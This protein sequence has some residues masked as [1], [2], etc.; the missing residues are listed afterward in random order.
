MIRLVVPGPPTGKGRPRFN[1]TTG[2]AYTPAGTERAENRVQLA[3]MD[4]GRPTL[5]DAEALVLRVEAVLGRPKSHYRTN[6]ALTAKGLRCRWP[7]RKPD[8]SN[9]VKVAEDALNG[10]AYRDDVL[11]VT[12]YV[13]KRWARD[14]EHEHTVVELMEAA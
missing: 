3:W 6:G 7:T 5:M 4:A 12:L 10:L 9:I 2:Q 11:I 8:A 1:R 13:Q 14:G